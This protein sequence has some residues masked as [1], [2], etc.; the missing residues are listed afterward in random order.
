M[1]KLLIA[2][3]EMLMRLAIRS[4]IDWKEQGVEIIGEAS[5]GKEA[6]EMAVAGQPDLIITDIKMPVMDGL[7]LIREASRSI[8][9]CTFVVLS[10]FDEFRYVREAMQLGA[11]DYLIKSEVSPAAV[12]ELLHGIKRK[13]R[14]DNGRSRGLALPSDYAQSLA[15]MKETLFKD[16]ISGL[17]E[18][19]DARE[20]A[21]KLG[22]RT[23]PERLTVMKIHID[24][25]HE[26]RK[27]YV[28]QDEKLLRFSIVNILE[29]II[30]GRWRKEIVALNSADYLLI[31]NVAAEDGQG[32][33]EEL[34]RL[35]KGIQQTVRD[36]MNLSLSIGIGSVV[37]SFCEL[38]A[39]YRTADQAVRRRFF[40][41]TGRILSLE[42]G[43][44]G[45]EAAE[46]PELPGDFILAFLNILEEGN[47]AKALSFLERARI[48]LT[49][50]RASERAVREAYIRLAEAAC[51]HLPFRSR[52]KTAPA[53]VSPFEAML[54][55][56]TLEGIHRILTDFTKQ[57]F[58]TGED[59]EEQL[60]H[61][62]RAA[63]IIQRYYAED[64]SLQSVASQINVNP[65][66]LSRVFK[67]EKG[68]NFIS[69]LTR[70]RIERAKAFLE[71]R[72]YKVYE[73][74]DKVGY[75]NY[76]YFS[77][78]FKKVTGVTPEEFRR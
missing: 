24:T 55:E 40:E 10:N 29:E 75:H 68:E 38:R 66:Y 27:K 45:G 58:I 3:D 21:E 2:D 17:L 49:A 12:T 26:I 32:V 72:K 14:E 59:P 6:L 57:I 4:L 25:F 42:N 76:T 5:N 77:K 36:F 15:H 48:R 16:L 52:S 44:P 8:S 46:A 51:A 56:E 71:S 23:R 78:I 9:G 37:S 30:P 53:P 39:S 69:Y 41:G 43:G 61:A 74:A 19:K 50:G 65:S 13:A 67:Q 18:E 47:E 28:E 1:L 64:L 62:D 7:Q 22:V 54:H 11:V 31:V 60:S 70:V 33:Q 63:H 20:Q 34:L 73:V 35:C